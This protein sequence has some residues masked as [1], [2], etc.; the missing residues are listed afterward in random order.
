MLDRLGLPEAV[1]VPYDISETNRRARTQ[2]LPVRPRRDEFP[3]SDTKAPSSLGTT[4][5]N[6]HLYTR[7]ADKLWRQAV[8]AGAKVL[9]PLED[10]FWGERYGKLADP[11]G[12]IWSLSMVVPMSKA[13]RA[14]KQQEAMAMFEKGAKPG[15][16]S[17][18]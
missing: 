17:W 6:I 10:Q 16:E 3:G 15:G 4:T 8:A 12:H 13:E 11:F 9:M 7:D 18:P 1:L 14:R 5:T 2:S